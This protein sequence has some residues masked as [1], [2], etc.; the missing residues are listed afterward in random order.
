MCGTMFWDATKKHVVGGQRV[1]I[2][3]K[4]VQHTDMLDIG[5]FYT[6]AKVEGMSGQR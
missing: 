5:Y 2:K 1:A 6:E 4:C 3:K